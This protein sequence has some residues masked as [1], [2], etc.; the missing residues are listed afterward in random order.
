M[1]YNP[2]GIDY[3]YSFPTHP[4]RGAGFPGIGPNLAASTLADIPGRSA[5]AGAEARLDLFDKC[6]W[7]GRR[8]PKAPD[9]IRLRR[10]PSEERQVTNC[11]I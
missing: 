7:S 4:R 8:R 6:L 5:V 11:T 10:E 3:P 2:G 1:I 9:G